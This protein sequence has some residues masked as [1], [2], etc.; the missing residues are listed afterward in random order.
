M[1]TRI[2]TDH[3]ESPEA[4]LK[5]MG[6]MDTDVGRLRPMK[7]GQPTP[8]QK[9]FPTLKSR[10][11]CDMDESAMD[12]DGN[13]CEP[14]HVRLSDTYTRWLVPTNMQLVGVCS[15]YAWSD[16]LYQR[17][18]KTPTMCP[19][20]EWFMHELT[21]AVVDVHTGTGAASVLL[22]DW[23]YALNEFV[24]ATH[25][26]LVALEF[27]QLS[28]EQDERTLARMLKSVSTERNVKLIALEEAFQRARRELITQWEA[29][30]GTL[31]RAVDVKVRE[32]EADVRYVITYADE[33][34]KP[35]HKGK[36][37]QA[38]KLMQAYSPD[39]RYSANVVLWRSVNEKNALTRDWEKYAEYD[40]NDRVWTVL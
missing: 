34:P 26:E 3:I 9:M 40:V 29:P 11:E 16:G 14:F 19:D 8:D 10:I 28:T 39:V 2:H 24:N 38:H 35:T 7:K 36:N 5:A 18:G 12:I 21:W 13:R 30:I 31:L 32:E 6:V 17:R 23:D 37:G 25:K 1:T 20:P 27:Q 15:V 22:G 33:S 4:L